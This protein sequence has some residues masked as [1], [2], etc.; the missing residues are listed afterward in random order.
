MIIIILLF[1]ISLPRRKKPPK[2]PPGG[3]GGGGSCPFIYSYDGDNYVFNALG[4]EDSYEIKVV[5]SD[6]EFDDNQTWTL[7]T[8]K[9]PI[10]DTYDGDTTNLFISIF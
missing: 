5:V 3:G 8:S 9:F 2:V 7:M 10:V 6:D 4:I 1:L